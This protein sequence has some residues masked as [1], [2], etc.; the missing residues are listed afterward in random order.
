MRI[1]PTSGAGEFSPTAIVRPV[2]MKF[3]RFNI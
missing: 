3:L 1:P 2:A